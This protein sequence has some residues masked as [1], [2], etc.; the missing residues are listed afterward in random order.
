MAITT[1]PVGFAAGEVFFISAAE[2]YQRGDD[3]ER[4]TTYDGTAHVLDVSISAYVLERGLRSLASQAISLE[5]PTGE[6][7]TVL[8]QLRQTPPQTPVRFASLTARSGVSRTGSAYTIWT[9]QGMTPYRA[10]SGTRGAAIPATS[11]GPSPEVTG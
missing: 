9:A 6:A 3:G 7:D 1:I 8:R 10:S 2:E 4:R 11:T 5:V